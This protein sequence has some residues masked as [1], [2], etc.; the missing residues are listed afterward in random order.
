RPDRHQPNRPER[1]EHCHELLEVLYIFGEAAQERPGRRDRRREPEREG[2]S[3]YLSEE[4]DDR[5]QLGNPGCGPQPLVSQ[6]E[7][8]ERIG[9]ELPARLAPADMLR[10]ERRALRCHMDRPAARCYAREVRI[11]PGSRRGRRRRGRENEPDPVEPISLLPVLSV[12]PCRVVDRKSWERPR[13]PV[14]R[15][16]ERPNEHR[17]A[18]DRLIVAVEIPI[19]VQ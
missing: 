8:V 2:L 5:L 4:P 9:V 1:P 16:A 17:Q 10:E 15:A 19:F 7:L 13:V 11:R 14:P 18:A 6:F 12:A 3:T